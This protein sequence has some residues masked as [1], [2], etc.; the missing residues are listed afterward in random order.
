M[1]LKRFDSF[2]INEG[3]A[4]RDECQDMIDK[5]DQLA[6][7]EDDET[8]IVITVNNTTLDVPFNADSYS[9]LKAFL[10]AEIQEDEELE[11]INHL[12]N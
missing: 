1:K 7:N 10:E 2:K 12:K 9:R 6:N 5:L 4:Y 3:E 8:D 11:A